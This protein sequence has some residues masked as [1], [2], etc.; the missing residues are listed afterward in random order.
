MRIPGPACRVCDSLWP[1]NLH[2]GKALLGDPVPQPDLGPLARVP[3]STREESP[4]KSGDQALENL[5]MEGRREYLG[6]LALVLSYAE[7]RPVACSAIRSQSKGPQEE[8]IPKL[9]EPSEWL[10]MEVQPLGLLAVE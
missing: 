2:F 1:W 7:V 4:S 6:L 5:D 8:P 9:L 3:P 10:Q